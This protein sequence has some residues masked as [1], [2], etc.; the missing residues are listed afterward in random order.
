[1]PRIEV[2]ALEQAGIKFK[3]GKSGLRAVK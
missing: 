1:M 2:R 3:P